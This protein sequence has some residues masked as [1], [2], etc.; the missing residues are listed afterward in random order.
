MAEER[1]LDLNEDE[2]I[3]LDAI[4]EEN[5]RGVAEECDNKKKIHALRWK[6]Y[7]KEKEEL[8]KIYF[9]VSVPHPKG[10]VNGLGL[11]EVS[12]HR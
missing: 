5:W 6:V 10:G 9:S 12:Y 7:V 8:I 11:C 3:R 1:D 2:D 4:R